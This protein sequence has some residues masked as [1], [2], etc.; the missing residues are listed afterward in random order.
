MDNSRTSVSPGQRTVL[1]H[2]EAYAEDH[3][4]DGLPRETAVEYLATHD[5]EAADARNRIETLL[6]KGYLY[7]VDGELRIPPRLYE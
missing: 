1:E 6:L 5:I 7:E 3:D 4:V 2:L